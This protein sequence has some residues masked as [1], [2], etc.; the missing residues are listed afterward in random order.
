MK[1]ELHL[2][3]TTNQ[4]ENRYKIPFV[5]AC[6]RA[7]AK[8]FNLSAKAAFRYLYIFKGIEF[9]DTYYDIEHL[10]SIEDTVDDLITL[11]KKE[12]GRL[13]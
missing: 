5:N 7:F 9:L 6:I 4:M 11:C 3:K 8:R 12:G 2:Y 1:K 10:Q 13:S